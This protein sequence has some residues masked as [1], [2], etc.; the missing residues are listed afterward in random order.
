MRKYLNY[1]VAKRLA[2]ILV[3]SFLLLLLSPLIFLLVV[4]LKSTAEHR[5]IFMQER[6]GFQ[7][8]KFRIWKFITMYANSSQKG[9]GDIT[10]KDDPRLLP[11]GKWL[12]KFKLDEIPQLVNLLRGD[13]SL[14]GPRPL[15]ENG[16]KRYSPE[17]QERIYNVKPGITGIG[18]IVFRDEAE[19]LNNCAD[20]EAT[21]QDITDCKGELELWYQQ[22][23]SLLTDARILFLTGWVIAFP[24]SQLIYDI[25]PT[26]PRYRYNDPLYV[27]EFQTNVNVISGQAV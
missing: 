22:N 10:I 25:F 14:V 7:N 3:S 6:M 4:F 27:S 24:Q 12:R 20:Y 2:D 8:R 17:V 26:L 1:F 5:V 15:M 21:Y 18:S 16:F 19:I 11:T 13:M 9:T 23:R